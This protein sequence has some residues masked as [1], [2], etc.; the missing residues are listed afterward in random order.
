MAQVTKETIQADSANT[1]L[2]PERFLKQLKPTTNTL[3]TRLYPSQNNIKPIVQ[4]SAKNKYAAR[5]TGKV[6]PTGKTFLVDYSNVSHR[7]KRQSPHRQGAPHR[8]GAKRRIRIKN[9]G[10]KSKNFYIWY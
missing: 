5:L 3:A 9:N 10:Q 1:N 6:R 7:H 4:T 2:L 8:R